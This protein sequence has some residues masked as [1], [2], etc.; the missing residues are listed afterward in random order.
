MD[1]DYFA[2]GAAAARANAEQIRQE[3][4]LPERFFL[5]VG[6]FIPEK[7]LPRLI[8]AFRA[9]SQNAALRGWALVLVG[10][11]ALEEGLR[12]QA[13]PLGARVRFLGF[14]QM[15]K[16]PSYYA[17]ASALVLPS[18]SESWGL[19]VNEAMS[20]GLP[21]ILSGQCGCVT[22]LVFPGVNGAVVDHQDPH[23]LADAL[24]ELAADA[25]RRRLYG[26]ASTRIVQNFSLETWSRALIQC[27][28]AL[29]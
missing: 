22:D 26:Q 7:N 23:S 24:I 29:R 1:N 9:A 20:A 17:L 27:S 18:V 12:Q 15:E 28:L 8:E 4:D 13:A 3:L 2:T 10:G 6:R 16:L 21:V 11:G 14:Q 25:E 19:V 5:F